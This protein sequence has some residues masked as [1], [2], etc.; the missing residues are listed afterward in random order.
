[1]ALHFLPLGPQFA[2]AGI[3][4]GVTSAVLD[5]KVKTGFSAAREI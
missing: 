3:K 4:A 1:V 5:L 2:R